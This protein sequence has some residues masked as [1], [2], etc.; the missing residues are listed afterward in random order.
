LV[1]SCWWWLHSSFLWRLL[2][3]TRI[4]D[5]G[6]NPPELHFVLAI[7]PPTLPFFAFS[8]GLT[9]YIAT[10]KV[11]GIALAAICSVTGDFYVVMRKV[12]GSVALAATSAAALLAASYGLWFGYILS[13][14]PIVT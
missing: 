10:E 9:L 3:T 13:K 2:L 1:R 5:R 8:M 12:S 14:I 11:D 6:E 4:A 7:M